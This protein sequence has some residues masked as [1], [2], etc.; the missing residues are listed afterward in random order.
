MEF[1][2]GDAEPPD[3]QPAWQALDAMWAVLGP[4]LPRPL[5]SGTKCHVQLR[6]RD[7][8]WRLRASRSRR[9]ADLAALLA[10]WERKTKLTQKWWADSTSNPRALRDEIDEL[11]ERF[12]TEVAGPYL[13][14]W[15]RY[16]YR[17]AIE[18]I[19]DARDHARDERFRALAL[20]Y[21]DLLQ[22]A[23]K[24]LREQPGVL[25]A[26]QEKY[27]WLFV[28]EFQDTDPIQAEVL[29]LLA[30]EQKPLGRRQKSGGS[31]SREAH[32]VQD[33]TQVVLRSGAL[34]IVGDPK[35]SIYRFR[36]ADIEIYDRVRRIVEQSG[37]RTVPLE[38]SFRAVPQ[39]CEWANEV[40]S[41]V[42]PAEPTP[43]QP[44]F[45]RIEPA[46]TAGTSSSGI[47]VLLHDEAVDHRDVARHDAARIA[48]YIR[49]EVT[50]GR[51]EP[52]DFLVL[53]W[54]KRQ[55]GLY[56][57]A[58][59]RLEIPVEV[60]GAG[61]FGE[62]ADVG[63]LAA[64][65]RT[66][67]DPNDGVA[68]VGVLRGPLFG[69]S[70]EELFGHRQAGGIFNLAV[71][72]PGEDDP[73]A[74]SP[75][76]TAPVAGHPGLRAS[77]RRQRHLD[78]LNLFDA[79]DK[80]DARTPVQEALIELRT[81][82]RWTRQ[83]PA[84]SAVELMLDRT[85]YLALAAAGT[86]GGADAGDLL[87]AVSRVR[88]VAEEG[89]TLAEAAAALTREI[90][91]SDVESLP[92]EPGRRD[93]VRVMNLHKAK[94]LE[95]TV[96]F[97][98]DPCS[99]GRR[100]VDIRIE[101]DG[102]R[103]LG[104]L[105][106]ARR[107]GFTEEVLAEPEG[108]ETLAATEHEF[109]AK[110]EDRLRYVAATRARDL[111]VVSR[112]AKTGGRVER[113]WAPFDVHLA[114]APELRTPAGPHTTSTAP[115]TTTP[116]DGARASAEAVRRQRLEAAKAPSWVVESVT[117]SE[118]KDLTV[119][120]DDPA[121]LL[122]GPATGLEWGDLVHKLL[123]EALRRGETNRP[124]L[125]RLARW[126][127][128]GNSKLASVAEEALDTVERVLNSESLSLARQSRE[129]HVEVPFANVTVDADG[130]RCIQHGVID[131]A[132]RT[133]DGWV[134]LDHKTDQLSDAG[135]GGLMD[136]YSG[137]LDSYARAWR[138]VTA[139]VVRTG[140][141]AVRANKVVWS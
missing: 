89:G 91:A 18:L 66:L 121:R 105:R 114:D 57:S 94:G 104:Y 5:P 62:S 98:A 33:W 133:P 78:Q 56:S 113:P 128:L 38:T 67:S 52:S 20:N 22:R 134:I 59:E 103:A 15:R 35:Q 90:D 68:L 118:R 69:L 26:L 70:D 63:E 81:M 1:P 71:P 116:S 6:A 86:P 30:S 27:R 37:G 120:E 137:Q 10:M 7:F 122:R 79:P 110:E 74:A 84:A 82:Y 115:D 132:Y 47:H 85:G 16:V 72:V 11:L 102:E 43:E 138:A 123:E 29:L 141:H 58:L 87:H 126:L 17:L 21:G 54:V 125:T 100:S 92:L 97:L 131:L 107:R 139:E 42:F 53:T 23:A 19:V 73:P 8:E 96:V 75:S 130:R 28:D 9:P 127:T 51:R 45:H 4:R 12:R 101:R 34:F 93:V 129:R 24:L 88:E 13:T 60:S 39:L 40:F 32:L 14:A 76:A 111:L 112:A 61:A 135:S 65:L 106:F 99:A 50:A 80:A 49:A 108:W 55:L 41:D 46:R 2:A 140:L 31:R 109:L 83:L 119:R 124:R 77:T 44:E 3:P 48:A 95:A 36:R 117:G 136:R 64:L 25:R